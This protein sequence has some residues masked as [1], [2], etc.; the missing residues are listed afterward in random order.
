MGNSN[1]STIYDN[2]QH[3]LERIYSASHLVGRNLDDIKVVVV[4]KKHP[5]N[6]VQRALDAGLR[7]FGENYAEEGVIKMQTL[8]CQTEVEWHMIGHIQSRKARSVTENYDWVH[9]LDSLKLAKRLDR[10]SDQTGRKLP[11]LLE[12]NVSGEGT[13]Y[14][15]PAWKE[16]QWNDWLSDVSCIL[17]LSYLE[18]HGLMTMAP[19]LPDPEETRPYFRRLRRLR[20]FLAGQFPQADWKELSMGM[21][22]DF[23]IAVQEGSTLVRIGTAIMGPRPQ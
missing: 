7:V 8:S 9:S 5:V 14:G 20:E 18:V 15:W 16:E 13:K 10:S 22:D 6:A 1:S 2:Y 11:V 23:E 17:E 3:V 4:T 12:F 19:L 21:S